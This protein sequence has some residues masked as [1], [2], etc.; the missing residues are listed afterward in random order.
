[1]SIKKKTIGFITVRTC[2]TR[3]PKKC[4][5]PFGESSV[6]AHIIRRAISYDIEPI[7]CTSTSDEDN[8]IVEIAKIEGVKFYRGSLVNKLKRWLDCAEYFN[9]DM[10]HT[11]D[12]D[13]P[14][15]DGDEMKNSMKILVE[16]DLDMV[17]PTKSSSS[18]GASVGYSLTTNLVKK[19]CN[20]LDKETDTEMMWYYIEKIPNLKTKILHETSENI[21]N[22][23]LTLDYEEDYW[24]LESVRKILGNSASRDKVDKLFLSNPDMYK[25]NW[26]R[27]EEWKNEQLSRML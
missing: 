13:D 15:F 12:A 2:S 1:M 18:G 4:L 3:L 20:T 23:R 5:L 19:T 26:F 6:L 16:E 10:F 25:L 17:Y 7:V 24:L 11:I 22:K 14:F 21:S 9:I 27:N 8:I